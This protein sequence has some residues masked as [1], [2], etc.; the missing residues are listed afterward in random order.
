[1]IEKIMPPVAAVELT[2]PAV[3]TERLIRLLPSNKI[4]TLEFNLFY[5]PAD[6]P[7]L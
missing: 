7:A 4:G 6:H 2:E 3:L 5:G 1:M